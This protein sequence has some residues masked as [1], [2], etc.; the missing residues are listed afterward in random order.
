MMLLDY[1]RVFS[2][3]YGKRDEISKIWANFGVL[4]HSVG[5]PRSSVGPRHG[6]V[7]R[8]VWTASG[9]P[10]HS[11]AMSR[12]RS[13]PQRSSA[14]LRHSNVHNMEIFVLCFVL[15]SRYSKDLSIGLMRTL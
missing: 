2:W 10:R 15:L 3:I 7:E 13:T 6:L 1:F 14:M 8:E 12:R 4:C 9:T 5:I 11:K